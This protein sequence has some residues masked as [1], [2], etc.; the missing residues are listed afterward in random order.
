MSKNSNV[1]KKRETVLPE[2]S[3][4]LRRSLLKGV[5]FD[6]QRINRPLIGVVNSWGENNPAARHIH[7]LAKAVKEGIESGGATPMEFCISSLCGGMAGGGPGARYALG[8]RDIAAAFIEIMAEVNYMDAL[9]LL[10]VCDDVVPAH[11]MAAARLDLPSILV[12]GGYMPSLHHEGVDMCA[13]DVSSKF[14]EREKGKVSKEEYFYYEDNSCQGFGACPWMG[15][16]NTMGAIAEALGM[17]LPGNSTTCGIDPK[18]LRLAYEAGRQVVELLEKDIR[19]SHIM[20]GDAFHNAVK[21]CSAVGGSSNAILHMPA[22][23]DETNVDFDIDLFD[24]Y[25][26]EIPQICNVKPT[27]EYLLKDLDEAGGLPAVMKELCP[28]LN[29]ETLTATGRTLGENINTAKVL[30]RKVIYSSSQPFQK[31]SGIG[32]L[33]GNLAPGG[34]IVKL[35]GVPKELQTYRGRA[36]VFN[37]E[38]EATNSLLKEEIKSGDVVVIRYL[39]PRGD[40]GMR[41]CARFLWI[42]SGMPTKRVALITDGRFSGT[43][44]GLGIGHVSPEAAVGGPIALVEDGDMIEIDIPNRKL[45]VEISKEEMEGRGKSWKVPPPKIEKGYLAMM[46]KLMQPPEKG[47][48]LKP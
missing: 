5:G 36:R 35:S 33:K 9:V 4:S 6:N 39:G 11:L 1:F 12:L 7:G 24:R 18:L 20:T 45:N 27:G 37:S 16:G 31:A 10:P 29:L 2:Y 41:V 14:A 28:L 26:M 17:T 38:V 19:P 23:A 48:T 32:I 30:N 42:L 47:A 22:I 13:F 44:K 40:P 43:N 25:S 34:A 46:E 3:L 21:V 15:T 8:Y